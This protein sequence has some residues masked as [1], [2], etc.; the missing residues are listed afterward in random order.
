MST[1][2]TGPENH[3][4]KNQ[5]AKNRNNAGHDECQVPPELVRLIGSQLLYVFPV[6]NAGDDDRKG[7]D[8]GERKSHV[9]RCLRPHN[10]QRALLLKNLQKLVDGKPKADHGKGCSNP[11]HECA[12]G[13][14]PG[15]V[16]GQNVGGF[17]FCVTH[18]LPP[19]RHRHWLKSRFVDLGLAF[20]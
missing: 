5:E 4:H 12:F 15:A 2:R 16:Q 20:Y 17:K 9:A 18:F 10:G 11:G 1:Q 3:A 19:A 6:L 13:S 14:H 7:S 8:A